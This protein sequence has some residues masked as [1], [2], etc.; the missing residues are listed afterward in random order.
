MD[1]EIICRAQEARGND[2]SGA[3]ETAGSG[4]EHTR[5]FSSQ[6][7]VHLRCDF[8]AA[9]SLKGR[10]KGAEAMP[11]APSLQRS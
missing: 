9:L 4:S 10:A 8:H 3:E 11:C 2:T 5:A 6:I 7:R 1:T